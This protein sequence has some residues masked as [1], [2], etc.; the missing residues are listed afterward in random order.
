MDRDGAPPVAVVSAG[1]AKQLWPGCPPQADACDPI[2]ARVKVDA[3]K[4]WATIVGVVGDV[5]MGGA[6]APQPSLYTS[7]RQDHWPGASWMVVR[8]EG[9]PA[10][11]AASV[12]QVVRRV[13][14][15]LVVVGLR[16]LEEF[17]QSTPAI[18]DRRVQMQLMAV[19][20]L[21]ALVVSAI[22]VYGV[23][24]Y[25]MEARRQEFGIRIALGASRCGVLWLALRD[26]ANAAAFGAIVGVPLALVL[27][28]RLRDLFYS[29]VPYD[30]VTL[31]VVL[32]GLSL[33]VLAASLAPARRATLVDPAK[34]MRAD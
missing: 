6:D 22:G 13:D 23:S 17:R 14:P 7:Q 9:D 3:N 20:A 12:R 15:T 21:A 26:G 25:A 1:L 33:V 8:A 32:A 34:A 24:A 11:V 30:P 28:W 18:A 5:R 16:T 27:A 2:G 4:P 10:A 19:F 31:A 29:T